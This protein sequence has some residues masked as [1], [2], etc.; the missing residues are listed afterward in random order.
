FSRASVSLPEYWRQL[1]REHQIPFLL[2]YRKG[3]KALKSLLGYQRLIEEARAPTDSEAR[4][5]VNLREVTKLL[6][7]CGPT[8]TEREGKQ[9][10]A[11][12]GIPVTAELLA[13]DAEAAVRA[14]NQLGYP[15]ALKVDSREITHKTEARGVEINLRNDEDVR[16][17][18]S[19]I[20]INAK[21]HNLDAQ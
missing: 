21:A 2:E 4:S 11:Y 12:Y 7:S 14:A 19:R 8:L 6:R 15:V 17:A 9:V 5:N 18:F 3:F 1:L 10:L 16:S 13:A 20:V